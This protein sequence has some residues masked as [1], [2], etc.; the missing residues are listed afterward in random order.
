MT[1]KDSGTFDYFTEAV[2][3]KERLIRQDYSGSEDD[4]VIV[5]G[6]ARNEFA[7]GFFGVAYF[8]A[9]KDKLNVVAIAKKAGEEYYEPTPDNVLSGKYPISRP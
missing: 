7:M 6:V 9:N 3:G 8:I 4:D 5:T 2:N 1:G